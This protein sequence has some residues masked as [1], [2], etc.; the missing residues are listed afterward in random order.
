MFNK[1]KFPAFVLLLA[2]LFFYTSSGFATVTGPHGKSSTKT[3]N[4]GTRNPGGTT[5]T[6]WGRG[7]TGNTNWGRGNTGSTNQNYGHSRYRKSERHEY[8]HNDG[9]RHRERTSTRHERNSNYVSPSIVHTK[10]TRQ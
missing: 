8:R 9:E 6:N 10:H 4:S 7:N 2:F 5:G 3:N 1:I